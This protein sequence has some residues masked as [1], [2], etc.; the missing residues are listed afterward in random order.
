MHLVDFFILK[1][2]GDN[3]LQPYEK[4]TPKDVM[5]LGPSN[6]LWVLARFGA[7]KGDYMFH[8]HNLIH[9]DDDMMRAMRVVDS[10]MTTN[11]TVGEQ[12]IT[13][14]NIIYSNYLYSDPM[15]NL[16]IATPSN[17]RKELITSTDQALINNVYRIFYPLPND[18]MVQSASNPWKVKWACDVP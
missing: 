2:E 8:C 10:G 5:Y 15:N 4:L 16:T 12:L 14:N 13:L 18:T 1:R 6:K 7:H 9:E 17:T 3:G 11:S